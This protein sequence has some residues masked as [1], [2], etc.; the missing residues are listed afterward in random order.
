M[1]FG[2]TARM[3]VL[4]SG[5][6]LVTTAV[7]G[8]V[9]YTK[10]RQ[11]L[12]A[13]ALERLGDN[14]CQVGQLLTSDIR[15][16]RVDLWTLTQRE[17]EKTIGH[18]L[19]KA[20][21]EADGDVR[22]A[23][24]VERTGELKEALH[25]LFKKHPS[26]T[27]A[28]FLYRRGGE[29]V[30]VLCVGRG[31]D[32]AFAEKPADKR[33]PHQGKTDRFRL[34]LHLGVRKMEYVVTNA[35]AEGDSPARC[36]MRVAIAV[37]QGSASGGPAGVL[38]LDM[39][40]GYRLNRSPEYLVFLTDQDGR[41]RVTP[42]AFCLTDPA[43]AQTAAATIQVSRNRSA[44]PEQPLDISRQ[45]WLDEQGRL[46]RSASLVGQAPYYLME[47]KLADSADVDKVAAALAEVVRQEGPVL[48]ATQ[49]VHSGA[50]VQL[51]S[52]DPRRLEE[53]V[54]NLR[55]QLGSAVS[56]RAPVECREL[57]LHALR[58]PVD[59]LKPEQHYVGLAQAV[60]YEGIQ[61]AVKAQGQSI[62][63]LVLLLSGAAAVLASFFSLILTRPLK[64]I[65]DTTERLG[66]GEMEGELPVRD[67]S[68]IGVLARSFHAM[69]QQARQRRIQ[70]QQNEARIRTILASAA[71]G[72]LTFGE[73]GK[74]ESFNQAAER[75]FGVTA[76]EARGRPLRDFLDIPFAADA[77]QVR[78]A[79]A[80]EAVG[81]R[82]DGSTLPVEVSI[83]EVPP[84][85]GDPR[86]FTAIVRDV[87]ER[88]R[89]EA[90][91]RELNQTLERRVEERT[92]ALQHALQELGVARDQALEASRAKSTFLAQ[93]SHELRTPLN[94][95][96]GY[97][98]LLQEDASD[99]GQVED[100]GRIHAA[101]KHLLTLIND[102]LDLSKIE[103][104]RI[105][106]CPETFE[107][108]KFLA[109]LAMTVRPLIDKNRNTLALETDGPPGVMHTDPTRL[110][111]CL[112]N[113]LSNASKFT[114]E[115]TVRLHTARETAEDREWLI[116]EVSD[117][118]IGMTPEEM[119]KL[120]QAFSQANASTTRK[121]GGTGLGLAITRRLC[122][123]MGG[124][125]TVRSEPGKG[126]TFTIRVPADLREQ[127][128]GVGGQESEEPR[129][130]TSPAA[131]PGA[132]SRG[133]VLVVDDD[134][135]VRDLLS[136]YLVKEGFHV[137]TAAGGEEGLRLAR[138]LHPRAITLDVMMPGTDG[139]TVL[140]T[141]K[142]DPA[143]AD[144]PV[145]MLTIVDDRNLGHAL[146]A[147]DYLSKPVDRSQLLSLLEK[148]CGAGTA[149]SA[150]VVEGEPQTR[151]QLRRLLEADGWTVHD[152]AN[153]RAA[154]EDI[155]RVQ[156][157]LIL[158]DLMT[159]ETDGF[160]LVAELRQ[161]PQWRS[162]PLVALTAKELT[163]E[164]RLFL[165]GS[166]LLSGC[167]RRGPGQGAFDREDLL[168]QV[169]E[170]LARHGR[171]D[172]PAG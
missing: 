67:R 149:G 109:D 63:W 17:N 3:A 36:L 151:A 87:T 110:K 62:F 102:V 115:G 169:H 163:P 74:V 73:D 48:R 160:E 32:G 158:L 1:K 161:H 26:Y 10:A 130:V 133:T 69:V 8:W 168:R 113:L 128:S 100:L 99:P 137:V 72:I 76:D 136:R 22:A 40:L 96:I 159:A 139:W 57:A 49:V 135:A 154:L 118:G 14:T 11:V 101:G 146:G 127:G 58:I 19:F 25:N 12:V 145:V 84:L 131:E 143:T 29:D 114:H 172:N 86:L 82:R 125:V 35:P 42:D 152:S 167:V 34:P 54:R 78:T 51:S 117:S 147:A 124:D 155:A 142:G 52:P 134:P 90:E 80:S 33:W 81:R 123:M 121:Y 56:W 47:G 170:L 91:I 71:E 43:A 2:I 95:I 31:P 104:G 138:E 140:N 23:P 150:L 106:L 132:A 13:Q 165:N 94:A 64:R 28:C 97:S 164:D 4:A 7:T 61:D 66:R 98:E 65:I 111:Q 119:G 141:L 46:F 27:G 122:Q 92:A 15:Q 171:G 38:V 108:E 70:L 144:I 45:P 126:S 5:L 37:Q 9:F 88:K 20:L 21:R 59:P 116:F 107:L 60:S 55:Q 83:S 16:Q 103:A 156:P 77:T 85:P 18:R 120:F 44:G 166:L 162:I 50:D 129:E 68:E 93:M 53:A 153:G 89:A 157:S 148:L 39:D 41:L 24:V 105:E 6:V 75:T 79:A 30:P 112:L